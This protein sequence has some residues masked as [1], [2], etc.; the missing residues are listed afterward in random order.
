MSAI[1]NRFKKDDDTVKNA[2]QAQSAP[3]HMKKESLWV[4]I[5]IA[6]HLRKR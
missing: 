4:R 1:D 6:L 3:K 2:A 5:L